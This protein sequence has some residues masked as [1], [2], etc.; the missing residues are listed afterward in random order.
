MIVENSIIS[1]PLSSIVRRFRLTENMRAK[2]GEEDFKSF[3]LDM[4]D[5]K[6]PLKNSH[7]FP[8]SIDIPYN[9][10]TS[11]NIVDD[12][13][14]QDHIS[15]HPASLIKRAI[16]CPT[17]KEAISINANILNRLPG[18]ARVHPSVDSIAH[19]SNDEESENYPI[20]FLNS[21]TIRHARP[22]PLFER[23]SHCD[24]F[25]KHQHRQ[26]YV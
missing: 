18:D 26:R 14:P 17:S 23:G 6:L 11:T 8:E 16:L 19:L 20:E 1:S 7:P 2:P 3:L 24:A 4:G 10:I 21:L 5:G 9:F 12:I 15:Q 22:Q 13:F 25:V